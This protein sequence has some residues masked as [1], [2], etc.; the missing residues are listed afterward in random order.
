[1][2]TVGFGDIVPCTVFGRIIVLIA[3][4]WGT[5]MISLLILS[6]GEIFSLVP[7]ES[8]SLQQLLQTRMAAK[9]ITASMRYYTS[10]NKYISSHKSKVDTEGNDQ[11]IG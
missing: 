8:K 4:I 2:A 9:A 7:N 6:V 3:A 11:L 1:M 10:K 5:F